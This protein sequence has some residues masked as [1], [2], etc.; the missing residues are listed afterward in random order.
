[1]F[2]TIHRLNSDY[3]PDQHQPTGVHIR[4]GMYFLYGSKL[5]FK[6]YYIKFKLQ[7]V[8]K[9]KNKNLYEKGML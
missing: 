3:F 6:S 2:H 5:N 7:S 1:M 4:D 8:N 9:A